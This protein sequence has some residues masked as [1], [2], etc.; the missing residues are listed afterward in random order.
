MNKKVLT[1]CAAMLLTGSLATIEAASKLPANVPGIELTENGAVITI[2][3]DVDLGNDYLL[4]STPNVKIVGENEATLKGRIVINA[5]NVTVENL[6]ILLKNEASEFSAYK[7]AITVVASSVTLRGN[8]ITCEASKNGYMAN[9]I[10]IFPTAETTNFVVDRNTFNG[11][12]VVAKTDG[13][14]SAAL[15]VSEGLKKFDLDGS[16]DGIAAVTTKA[17]KGFDITSL[18]VNTYND[19]GVD[20]TYASFD[21]SYKQT[22]KQIQVEPIYDNGKLLNESAIKEMVTKSDKNTVAIFRGTSEEFVKIFGTTVKNANVAIQC[23][24][25]KTNVLFGTATNPDNEYATIINGVKLLD[26]KVFSLPLVKKVDANKDNSYLLIQKS[27]SGDNNVIYSD[28]DGNVTYIEATAEVLEEAATNSNYLWAAYENT[29]LDGNYTIYF[30]NKAG[31]TFSATDKKTVNNVSYLNGVPLAISGADLSGTETRYYGLYQVADKYFQA[32]DLID[33]YG[34]YFTLDITYKNDKDKDVDV[35]GEFEGQLYPVTEVTYSNGKAKYTDASDEINFMLVNEKGNIIVIDK[36]NPQYT[37]PNAHGYVFTT[38]TPKE[39]AEWQNASATEKAKHDYVTEFQFAYDY[40]DKITTEAVTGIEIGGYKV[41]LEKKGSDIILVADVESNLLTTPEISFKLNAGNGITADKW[42]TTPSYYKVEFINK[43][44]EH[45][46]YGKVLGLNE[47]GAVAWVAPENVDLT[48]PEGQFAISSDYTFTN[49]ENGASAQWILDGEVYK[50]ADNVYA[51][52]HPDWTEGNDTLRIT[53]VTTYKSNDGFKRFTAAE[54][55]ANTYT[56]AMTELS[57]GLNIIENHNDKHRVGLDEENATEWRIEMPTVKLVD[58][59]EDFTRMAADTVKIETAIEYYSTAEKKWVTTS[60]DPESDYYAPNTELQIC[61]YVLKNTDN[62]EYLNGKDYDESAGN[63]YYVCNDDK[64]TGTRIA[65]KIEGD[66]TVNLVP[67]YA[68]NDIYYYHEDWTVPTDDNAKYESA[69][70]SYVKSLRLSSNKIIG[71]T[72]T[73]TG[74]LKDTYLYSA[75][76]NDVFTINVAEAPTY[77]K[78]AQGDKIILTLKENLKDENVLFE[79]G[80][81]AGMGNRLAHTDINPTLYVDTAYVNRVGNFA[82]QYLLGVRINR[83]DTTYQCNVPAHGTH[84]ADTTYG[85]FLVNM[86]DSAMANKDVH[87]N[88]YQYNGEYKLAFVPGYHTNDTLFFTNKAGEV[89]SKMEVGNGD[90]N[91]AKFAFKMIDEEANEFVVETAAGYAKKYNLVIDNNNHWHWTVASVESKPGYLRWVNDNLVVTEN[92]DNAAVF[93]M[94]DSELNATAN[95]SITAEGAVSVVA[96]DGAVVIK[97]AEGKNV[98]IA[99]ILGKVVANETINSDNET[100]AV[101]AGIAVVS[102]DGES[103]KV[104]VK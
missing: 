14:T 98:V 19:C 75:P 7:N 87:N 74:A 80:E 61:T 25:D 3:E 5:E 36:K 20:Y 69:Y 33:R 64:K 83:V 41:G 103:F 34:D 68:Y 4:I 58:A 53:P 60:L 85:D 52:V 93:T 2:N 54:L 27:A 17:L 91:I 39:W 76:S 51:V 86:V 22:N 77:K 94:E 6:K 96:T 66:S 101:P 12:K 45:Y 24:E 70:D 13:S 79:D 47:N 95:E 57:G 35:T 29:D 90:F 26:E 46:N 88:K 23:T 15:L 8:V 63:A 38:I 43:D 16:E 50:V 99:T 73:A 48:K 92:I 42:L 37:A 65:F 100:I 102:V 21:K 78:L 71:A 28:K 49:R 40:N 81:F 30:K 82:Y 62:G 67:V 11:F 56:I 84:R 55:N 10:S 1:L 18:G 104:V 44:K 97:G 32:N 72:T 89:V 9:G 59:T 31:V